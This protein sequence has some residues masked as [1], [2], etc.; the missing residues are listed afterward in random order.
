MSKR[1][2]CRCNSSLACSISSRCNSLPCSISR[3]NSLLRSISRRNSLLCSISRCNSLPRSISRRNGLPCSISRRNS[4]HSRC[5]SKCN[6]RRQ[7]WC[8]R[9]QST[10]AAA[11][12]WPTTCGPGKTAT[13]H[14]PAKPPEPAHPPPMRVAQGMKPPE[15]RG[16]SIT[17]QSNRAKRSLHH[18]AKQSSAARDEKSHASR[19]Q[20][21]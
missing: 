1:S 18:T 14:G 21:C 12:P 5:R 8:N 11:R 7:Q 15:P 17:Q 20:E 6:S 4:H 9:H 16:P 13:S 19:N 10:A 3:R 2:K